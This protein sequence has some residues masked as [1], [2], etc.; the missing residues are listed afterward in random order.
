MTAELAEALAERSDVELGVSIAA[1]CETRDE[2]VAAG[3]AMHLATT[4]RLGAAGLLDLP[5]L[6]LAWL[7][8][9]RWIS[10][11]RPQAVV[12]VMGSPWTDVVARL[13]HA[14]VRRR[15]GLLVRFVHD[16]SFH[17]GD[18]LHSPRRIADAALRAAD[19]YVVLSAHVERE[20]IDQGVDRHRIWRSEHGPFRV[21]SPRA[22]V[23]LAHTPMRA[24]FFGR[25]APYKGVELLV[26]ASRLL[27]AD[28]V[29]VAVRIVGDGDLDLG[30]LPP[31][32][33]VQRRWVP[34]AE[35]GDVL[36][37][38]DVIVLPYVEASQ[39]GV[40]PMA[41]PLGIPVIVTPVGGLTEQ[42]ADGVTGV[43]VDEV[44][45]ASIAAAIRRLDGDPDRYRALARACLAAGSPDDAWSSI[46]D[47]LVEQISSATG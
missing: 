2:I 46:A 8:L 47:R 39:S 40:A 30:P 22:E 18:R 36:R 6:V 1:R 23:G 13:L 19:R 21:G 41:A 45:A 28:G 24:L 15:R 11:R 31:N 16:A 44:D 7:S 10:A 17:P 5:G 4:P 14:H 9:A 33:E 20:L 29:D 3:A 38:A 37:W 42:V 25:L 32:V 12:I 35:V 34:D 43:V 26:D 27:A